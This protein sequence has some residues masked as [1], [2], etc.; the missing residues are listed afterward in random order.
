MSEEEIRTRCAAITKS[1]NQCKNYAQP[2]TGYCFTHREQAT[3]AETAAKLLHEQEANARER[4]N[5]LVAELDEMV[6]ELQASIPKGS[7]SAYSPL[8]LLTLLRE[9]VS[10]LSPEVQLGI[11][12]S[13]AGTTKEDLLDIDTWKGMA[14]MLGYSAKFQA[15]QVKD[16]VSERLPEPVRPDKLLHFVKASLDKVTP[17]VA[18]DIMGS[19]QG[20]SKEDFLDPDTWKGLWYMINYSLQFQADQLK[21]RLAGQADDEA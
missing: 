14:Y 13:F 2:H 3:A 5:Q 11:L 15:N 6:S 12:E 9:N 7:A 8:R 1:G 19:L 18:K 16:R 10:R 17:T 4:L 20:A 21:Q